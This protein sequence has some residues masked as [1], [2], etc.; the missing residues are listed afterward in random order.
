VIVRRSRDGIGKEIGMKTKLGRTVV[1]LTMCVAMF[2]SGCWGLIIYGRPAGER[3]RGPVDVGVIV[4][5]LLFGGLIAITIDACAGTLREP[6]NG[7]QVG[8]REYRYR[9]RDDTKL[10][11]RDRIR[12]NVRPEDLKANGDRKLTISW[13]GDASPAHELYSGAVRDSCKTDIPVS[14]CSGTGKLEVKVDG[15]TIVAW[16]ARVAGLKTQVAAK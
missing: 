13:V 4:L 5:D 15:R 16:D 7:Q 2:A 3:N 9:P 8:I 10:E 6:T 12:I 14:G 11:L 1:A